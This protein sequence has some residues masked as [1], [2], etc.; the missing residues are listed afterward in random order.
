M[1][2][3]QFITPATGAGAWPLVAC[4][5]RPIP[6][7]GVLNGQSRAESGDAEGKQADAQNKTPAVFSRG[8]VMLQ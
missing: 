2:R 8:K 1:R 7:I 6:V 5:Q 4:A 3:R